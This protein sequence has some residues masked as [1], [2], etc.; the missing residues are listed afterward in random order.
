MKKLFENFKNFITEGEVVP[1]RKPYNM[2]E[3]E[4]FTQ[5]LSALLATYGFQDQQT[6]YDNYGQLYITVNTNLIKGQDLVDKA[7]GVPSVVGSG[8]PLDMPEGNKLYW[9]K[10]EDFE[11]PQDFKYHWEKTNETPI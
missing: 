2:N 7:E 9:M 8:R 3:W 11:D 4:Q 10:D 6:D 1:F 5:E